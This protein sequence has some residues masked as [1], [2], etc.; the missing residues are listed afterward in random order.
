MLISQSKTDALCGANFH[1]NVT[2]FVEN[3]G[4]LPW[5][6]ALYSHYSSDRHKQKQCVPRLVV[7]NTINES[8]LSKSSL[9]V[10]NIYTCNHPDFTYKHLTALVVPHY[11]QSDNF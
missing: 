9:Q 10:L 4:Q 2:M 11:F 1:W 7:V 5:E 6:C 3:C 8:S